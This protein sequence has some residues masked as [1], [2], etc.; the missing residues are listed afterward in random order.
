MGGERSGD[1]RAEVAIVGG[2]GLYALAGLDEAREV[3]VDTPYGAHSEGLVLGTID[4]RPTAFLARHGKEHGILP[5]EVNYRANIWALKSLGVERIL[6]ASAVG[7]MR[8]SIRPRDVVLVDQFIDRSAHRAAT[9]FGG[10][11]VAH[12]A[13]A[14]PICPETHAVLRAL[15][16]GSGA[17]V[18]DRGT[19]VCIEGPAFST[20][21]ESR[22]YRSWDVDVIGMTN[23]HEAKL[24]RE[25]EICYA[26]LALVTDFD[27]W[28]EE[29]EDVS[30]AA[31][32]ENLRANAELAANI[33]RRAVSVLPTSRDG[34]ACSCADALRHALITPIDAI[35]PEAR[36]RLA[37]ILG[38]YL[39]AD[40]P[41]PA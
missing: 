2:S 38:R 7:S 36:R 10:G 9:F 12:I 32:L 30:V 33:L 16:H 23:L 20:R 39:P 40:G 28:H 15:L 24:A 1:R 11:V 19:Y 26:T 31:L 27:C 18:H 41:A 14:D 5:A 21:A 29:E 17:Q 37:P 25:A 8:E 35:P 4:G 3:H 22:L 13:F 6:S 34:G